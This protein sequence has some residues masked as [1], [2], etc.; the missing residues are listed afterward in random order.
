MVGAAFLNTSYT[1]SISYNDDAAMFELGARVTIMHITIYRKQDQPFQG[2]RSYVVQ[3]TAAENAWDQMI[4]IRAAMS[5]IRST[6]AEWL[7]ISRHADRYMAM[8][9]GPYLCFSRFP[10]ESCKACEKYRL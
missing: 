3:R 8:T 1:T 6:A 9:E 10:G 7:T 5:G 2:T 4:G